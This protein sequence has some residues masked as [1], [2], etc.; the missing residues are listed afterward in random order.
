MQKIRMMITVLV[1]AFV[2]LSC[3][4]P[5]EVGQQQAA[6]TQAPMQ[7]TSAP[8]AQILPTTLPSLAPTTP[9]VKPAATATTVPPAGI[10]LSTANLRLSDLPAGFQELDAATQSQVGLTPENLAKA[11]QSAF[12]QAKVASMG[13]FV[14]PSSQSYEVVVSLVFHPLAQAEQA[15]FDQELADPAKTIATFGQGFGG[16]AEVLAGTNQFGNKSVGMTFTTASGAL[17]L[18]GDMVIMRRE[19]AAMLLMVMYR[20][21]SKPPISA[22]TLCPVLDGRVKTA[23]GK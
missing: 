9:P 17:I 4:L 15:A 5:F 21:G 2:V 6:P 16:K 11:F 20:D 7:A 12:R 22:L 8:T 18:R 14:N 13:A 10:D 23:L 1:T 3:D 19:S